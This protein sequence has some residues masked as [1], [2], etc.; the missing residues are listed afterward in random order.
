[1]T[2]H[3]SQEPLGDLGPT[4]ARFRDALHHRV[5]AHLEAHPQSGVPRVGRDG[6]RRAPRRWVLAAAVMTLAI[7]V[8][9]GIGWP[10]VLAFTRNVILESFFKGIGQT[11]GRRSPVAGPGGQ[12]GAA[13]A[14][15]EFEEASVRACDPDNLPA[16]PAGARGGGPN[17][18]YMTPGRTYALCMTP[19]ALI[20]TAYGFGPGEFPRLDGQRGLAIDRVYGL[21]SERNA[22]RVRGG[23]DWV[24]N[25]RYTIEAVAAD[26][27]NA[28]VMQGPMLRALLEDRFR[29]KA[30]V[31]TE[32][33][34]EFHLVIAPGGAKIKGGACEKL[35]PPTAGAPAQFGSQS[36][37]AVRQGA[38]PFCGLSMKTNGANQ[39]VI[40]GAVPL[41]ALGDSLSGALGNAQVIDRTGLADV[42]NFVFEFAW[43]EGQVGIGPHEPAAPI[44]PPRASAVFAAIEQQL[45]LRLEPV[46]GAREFVVI[47]AIERPRPN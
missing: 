19:A 42:F 9:M 31:E 22:V 41:S 28:A 2:T 46:R 37:D 32:D 40:G 47:D 3:D 26:G 17:S 11:A 39:V 7:A 1:M 15:S 30:H 23:P 45:G 12:A 35:P 18:F 24:R 44:G 16:L 10:P 13:V 38:A 25:E 36:A 6:I 5:D 29:L 21:G 27:A 4:V 34:P 8:G 20:R 14:R 43:D 33:V